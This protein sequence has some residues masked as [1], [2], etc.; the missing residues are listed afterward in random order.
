VTEQ[1]L[2]HPMIVSGTPNLSHQVLRTVSM[3]VKG[4]PLLSLS[5]DSQMSS[6]ALHSLTE[7]ITFL[8]QTALKHYGADSTGK[9]SHLLLSGS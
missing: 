1:V 3:V 9:Y 2:I 8:R 5:N 6:L 7:S 4:L